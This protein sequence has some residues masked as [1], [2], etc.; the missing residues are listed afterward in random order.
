MDWLK[1]KW[2]EE[3]RES[4]YPWVEIQGGKALARWQ[5]ACPT[6]P[7]SYARTASRVAVDLSD[8]INDDDE[9]LFGDAVNCV[10]RCRQEPA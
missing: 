1:S 3:G 6:Q 9:P 4:S 8:I 7:E 10:R 2:S 5:K